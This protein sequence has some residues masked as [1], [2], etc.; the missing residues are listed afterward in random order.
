MKKVFALVFVIITGWVG[1]ASACE[2]CTLHNGLGQYNNQGDFFSVTERYTYASAAVNW[3][4]V[5]PAGPATGGYAIQIN[6][7]QMYYQ[8]A[9]SED[10]KG[11][12]AIP[13]FDKRSSNTDGGSDTSS[14]PGDITAMLRYKI[15]E[16]DHD[17]FLGLLGGLKL[18]TGRYKAT[19]VSGPA[20]SGFFNPDLVMGSGS[21]DELLGFVYSQNVGAFSLALDGLYKF[22]NVG[23][24]GYRFGNVMNLGLSGYYK[25]SNSFNFGLG[26]ASEITASDSDNSGLTLGSPGVV[27]NTGGSVVYLSPTLQYVNQNNYVD[28]SYQYPIY[29]Y[30]NGTQ[31]VVDNKIII[32]YRHAF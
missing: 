3:G 18:P 10:L 30:F 25:Y 23:Y 5:Q 19:P 7:V 28:L 29:R 32:A 20:G 14:G 26:F 17:Q 22:S 1:R 15:W 11:L 6:T 2:F 31:T 27:P 13:W 24:D 4:T 8:H 16:G 9:F 12:F 21:L